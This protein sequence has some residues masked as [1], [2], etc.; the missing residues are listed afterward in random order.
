MSEAK[1]PEA[2]QPRKSIK[3][4]TWEW[5][6]SLAIALV[7][8]FVLRTLLVE[9]FR[10]PSSSME[11]TLLVGDFLF[12]N[13]AL[14]GAELP[15]I[16]TRLPSFREPRLDDIVVFDSRTEAG[17]E[18]VK[19]LVGM[20]GDTLQMKNAVLYRNG[21][22]RREPYVEHADSL[23]DT[24]APEMREWQLDYVL[25]SVAKAG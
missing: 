15:L 10:I 20:P 22:A 4:A 8:W 16:H 7:I 21:V 6:K 13:K 9:A 1:A 18:V 17:V 3:H 5:I 25:P 24:S 19:R 23:G 11:R 14:Y 12:V 2:Q